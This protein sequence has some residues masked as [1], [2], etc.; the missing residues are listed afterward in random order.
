MNWKEDHVLAIAQ[1]FLSVVYTTGYFWVLNKFLAG[2]IKTPVEWKDVLTALISLL[3][4]GEL[5]IL[6][7]WFSRSRGGNT[8]PASS[9]G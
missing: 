7:F 8:T 2:Q 1:I 5:M 3:T 4:A 9:G 6:Q